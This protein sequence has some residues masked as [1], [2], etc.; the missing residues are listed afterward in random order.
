MDPSAR[1]LRLLSLLQARPRWT[2][3]ELADRLE[4]TDRTLRR[5]INRLRDLGYPVEA[6]TGPAG[7]YMLTPGGALPPLLLDDDE[8]VVVALGLRTAAGGSLP[9]FE[10]AAVAALAKIEQVLPVRLQERIGDIHGSTVALRSQAEP[11]AALDPELLVKLARGCRTPER[12]RF[13]YTD[14]KGRVTERHVE[15]YQLVHAA[16]R[17]YLVARDRDREAWRTFRVD[18][19]TNPKLTGMR[20]THQSPP[21]AAAQVSEGLG[22]A[23]WKWRAR[24]LLKVKLAEA[25]HLV[26]PTIGVVEAT[27]G[28]TLLRIGADELEW[29]AR[30]LAGLSCRFRILEPPELKDAV[31]AL[32]ARLEDDAR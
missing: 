25:K 8:A 13:G 15:P 12:M 1:M 4:V 26:S 28:G 2:G 5:D 21:D 6:Y 30:Y 20:F 32:I 11:V 22:V 17:W 14:S 3:P 19:I 10:D 9:G 29:I 27:R 18:R 16:R 24:V 31:R 7:G 23:V